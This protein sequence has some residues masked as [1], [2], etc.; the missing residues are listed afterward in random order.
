MVYGVNN[1]LP[2]N[3]RWVSGDEELLNSQPIGHVII[4]TTP[5]PKHVG[6]AIDQLR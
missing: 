3:V 1:L 4:L 5:A 6:E 2:S